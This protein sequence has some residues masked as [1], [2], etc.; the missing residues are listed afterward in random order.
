M[1]DRARP[2]QRSELALLV[3]AEARLDGALAAARAEAAAVVKAARHCAEAGDAALADEI[4]AQ[5]ARIS[6]RCTTEVETQ[7]AAIADAARA[8]IA[9]YEAIRG[10]ALARLVHTAVAKLVE[11]VRAEARSP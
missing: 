10:D 7:C 4:A 9:R 8:E 5:E 11:I 3:S 1:T 2:K 6:A